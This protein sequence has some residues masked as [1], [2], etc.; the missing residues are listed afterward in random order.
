MFGYNPS[1]QD[2][3]GELIGAG[4]GQAAQGI[5]GAINTMNEL[6]LKAN[7]ADGS[8]QAAH[9]MGLLDADSLKQIQSLPWQQK[10]GMGDHLTN[11]VVAKTQADRYAALLGL[12][13]QK[14]ATAA[15][16]KNTGIMPWNS[17]P[18]PGGLGASTA[19]TD[20]SSE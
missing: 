12:N 3:S 14:A 11:M 15:L 16:S 10:I 8:A 19:T 13:Q 20:A 9:S 5:S 17:T 6:Q 18:A 4:I 7:Q 2:R 1:V